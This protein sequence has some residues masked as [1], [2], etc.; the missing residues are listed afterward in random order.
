[1]GFPALSFTP[2]VIV[3]VYVVFG[4]KSEP[5]VNVAVDPELVTVP[6]TVLLFMFFTVNDDVFIVAASI[7]SLN[8]APMFMETGTRE[9]PL[10]GLVRITEGG[11]V[12]VAPP[13]SPL[14]P[15]P[16]PQPAMPIMP[17]SSI[18]IIILIVFDLILGLL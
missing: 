1:M 17:A 10:T 4:D 7:F 9:S 2:V 15:P 6:P 14:P 3:A 5:G 12:S 8:V 13:A 11:V 16:P 18:P